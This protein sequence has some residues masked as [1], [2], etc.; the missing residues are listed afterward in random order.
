MERII[1]FTV[2]LSKIHKQNLEK[3]IIFFNETINI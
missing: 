1:T 2:S 3:K